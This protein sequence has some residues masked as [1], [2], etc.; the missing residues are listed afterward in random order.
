MM[1][2]NILIALAALS[3]LTVVGLSQSIYLVDETNYAVVQQFG[4]I[5]FVGGEA[6]P[7][8]KV[9]F[10]QQVTYF[11]KRILTS[12]TSAEEY[13]T[14]DEKRI[15]VD[16]VTRWRIIEP[17]S[18]YLKHNTE[19]QGR[20]RLERLV[21]GALRE[22]IAAR[23]YDT[24]ISSER[25]S[26]MVAVRDAVQLQVEESGWGIEVVDVRTKRADLPTAVEQ[27]VYERMASDRQVEAMRHRAEGQRKSD[28]ITSET[29]RNVT[30]MDACASR[31]SKEIMGTG[32]AFAIAIF[33]EALQQDPG[34]FAFIRRLEA[35][36]ASFKPED[37]L[38]MSTDTNF[39]RLLT[40]DTAALPTVDATQGKVRELSADIIKEL[41]TD[42]IEEYIKECIPEVDSAIS[43]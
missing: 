33:A 15:V 5:K 39:F 14:S 43:G 6:G 22:Q 18:F 11:D 34:F 41:T 28:Q 35:Y 24:M 27:S 30:I 2:R 1:R 25:D 26:I 17:R 9:P 19:S 12:D 23:L 37:R 31:L 3:L 36:E 29:D 13:L 21:L 10:V 38:I 4:D 16:Q 32:E 40:G 42:E 20:S 8:F 7:S